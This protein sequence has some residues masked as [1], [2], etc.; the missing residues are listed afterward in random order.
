MLN[1]RDPIPLYYQVSEELK[2]RIEAGV[3]GVG[4]RIPPEPELKQLFKVSRATVRSAIQLLV[5]QGLLV[6]RPG[7][8]TFVQAAKV[9]QHLNV[10]TSWTETMLARGVKVETRDVRL[11]EKV[12]PPWVAEALHLKPGETAVEVY[13]LRFANDEPVSIMT[14]YLIPSIG[15]RLMSIGMVDES[16]YR[17]L[18]GELGVTLATAHEVVRAV[19]ATTEQ[20]K[21]LGVRR[22]FPLIQVTRVTCGPDGQ[23]IEYVTVTSRADRYQYSVHLAGR[24]SRLEGGATGEGTA[25][26]PRTYMGR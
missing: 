8:G 9:T 10:I 25:T 20:A 7:K 4:D 1:A 23:P 14:N 5:S 26:F 6:K 2:A 16:L 13:R 12:P 21:C 3:Y 24:P 15:K 19:A 18:E 11:E 22:G 17:I